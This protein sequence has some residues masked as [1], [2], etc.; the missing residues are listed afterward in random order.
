MM[1]LH[2]NMIGKDVKVVVEPGGKTV[3]VNMYNPDDFYGVSKRYPNA[4][5][6]WNKTFFKNHLKT[7]IMLEYADKLYKRFFSHRR[8]DILQVKSLSSISMHRRL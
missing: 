1:T 8:L 5:K 7:K 2:D 3:K 4:S 6:N